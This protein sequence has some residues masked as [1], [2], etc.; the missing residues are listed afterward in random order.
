MFG[1]FDL[2]SIVEAGAKLKQEVETNLASW[3]QAGPRT[4]DGAT[5]Q[6]EQPQPAPDTAP[7]PGEDAS[8]VVATAAACIHQC[9][10]VVSQPIGGQRV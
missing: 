4:E 6:P 1:G 7:P 5:D 3:E 2:S 8:G 9:C 10:A